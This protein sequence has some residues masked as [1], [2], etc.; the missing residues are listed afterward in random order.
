MT[1]ET[2]EKKE[3]LLQLV[4]DAVDQDKTLREKFQVGDKFRF[5]RERLQA[6][7]GRVEES[8]STIEAE[9]VEKNQT[10]SEDELLVYV[11]LYNAQ[12]LVLQTWHKML[13]PQVFYEY[14]VN[15]PIYQDKTHVEAF[16]R[17]KPNKVQHGFLT[18]IIKKADILIVNADTAKDALSNPLVKVRENSLKFEKLLHFTQGD[19]EYTVNETGEL[20]KRQ[21]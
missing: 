18:V 20:I 17:S 9:A 14:S 13:K 19:L 3:K 1:N 15:R 8:L 21:I 2:K 7:L 12:G 5:I 16:I 11:Y 10:L 4:R 6:L